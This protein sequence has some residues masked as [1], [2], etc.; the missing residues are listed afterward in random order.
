VNFKAV[1]DRPSRRLS[2]SDIAPTIPV[3]L[4]EC[5]AKFAVLASSCVADRKDKPHVVRSLLQQG[6]VQKDAAHLVPGRLSPLKDSR[7]SGSGSHKQA[8]EVLSPK[9]GSPTR[10]TSPKLGFEAQ[11][12]ISESQSLLEKIADG[13]QA[14][15]GAS[16]PQAYTYPADLDDLPPC[17]A[18]MADE[19]V[20]QS[21]PKDVQHMFDPGDARQVYPEGFKAPSMPL[22]ELSDDGVITFTS[23]AMPSSSSVASPHGQVGTFEQWPGSSPLRR[24]GS[25][26]VR[27]STPAPEPHHLSDGMGPHDLEHKPY[28]STLFSTPVK[29]A[30]PSTHRLGEGQT[31]L[32]TPTQ[33]RPSHDTLYSPSHTSAFTANLMST[34]TPRTSPPVPLHASP[35]ARPILVSPNHLHSPAAT[36]VFQTPRRK[37]AMEILGWLSSGTECNPRMSFMIVYPTVGFLAASMFWSH[38]PHVRT[39]MCE[40]YAGMHKCAIGF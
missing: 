11:K 5:D 4:N 1:E 22:A 24:D 2:I 7:G 32:L 29:A 21:T 37:E 35:R 28:T 33:I 3:P 6:L 39:G 27:H 38:H 36:E 18:A 12:H 14:L 20:H 9:H 13:L 25:E 31:A 26:N 40:L 19:Y 34:P 10:I 17:A 16:H 23:A 30:S 15:E 8:H